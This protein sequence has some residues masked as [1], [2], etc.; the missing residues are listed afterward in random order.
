M[1]NDISIIDTFDIFQSRFSDVNLTVLKKR[2]MYYMWK[3]F[4]NNRFPLFNQYYLEYHRFLIDFDDTNHFVLQN[5]KKTYD[6][7]LLKKNIQEIN[8]YIN[9]MTG[10]SDDIIFLYLDDIENSMICKCLG[11]NIYKN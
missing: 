1:N 10:Y 6:V 9:I 5:I 3:R 2:H 7:L 8:E 4:Y 11:Y